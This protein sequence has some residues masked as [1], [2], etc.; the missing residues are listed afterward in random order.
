MFTLLWTGQ[1]DG[2][3]IYHSVEEVEEKVKE[4]ISKGYSEEDM[5]VF[6]T[7]EYVVPEGGRVV[8][9]D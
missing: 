4:L 2:W 1:E 8:I 9:P 3:D 5:M 6:Y 7:D